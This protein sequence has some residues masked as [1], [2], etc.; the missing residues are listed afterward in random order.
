M[1]FMNTATFQSGSFDYL[2]NANEPYLNYLLLLIYSIHTS[3][4]ASVQNQI[5]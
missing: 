1:N 5:L 4:P 3:G 2:K